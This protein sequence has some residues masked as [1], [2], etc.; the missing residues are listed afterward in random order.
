[1]KTCLLSTIYKPRRKPKVILV[2]PIPAERI[3]AGQV[4]GI[5]KKQMKILES[6][7]LKETLINKSAVKHISSIVMAHALLEYM[8]MV[9][10]NMEKLFFQAASNFVA[11][12]GR[13]SI[14]VPP[15][16]TSQTGTP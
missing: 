6:L 2:N 8:K 3:F 9:K 12:S 7:V 14:M 1:M 15:P 4:P 5:P 13:I 10:G 11:A 16:F